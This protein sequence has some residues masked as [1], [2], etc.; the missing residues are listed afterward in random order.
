MA[1]I[2]TIALEVFMFSSSIT[3]IH[4]V[5]ITVL[6]GLVLL[7]PW[8]GFNPDDISYTLPDDALPRVHQGR[9]ESFPP[10]HFVDAP[11][12]IGAS[13]FWGQAMRLLLAAAAVRMGRCLPK[14]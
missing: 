8:L 12:S 5:L 13:F 9:F 14:S 7:R 11:I 10:R 1:A 2:S 4:I 3:M 6:V